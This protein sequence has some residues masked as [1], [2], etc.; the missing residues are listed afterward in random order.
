[1]IEGWVLWLLL[2]GL[3]LGCVATWL[4]MVRLPRGEGDVSDAERP[5]E[6]AWISSVIEYHG[7][8]A[9]RSLVEEVLD[10]HQVYL[11]R[12]PLATPPPAAPPPADPVAH[13][14]QLTSRGSGGQRPS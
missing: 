3:A 14:A 10:L 5:A 4:L 13:P 12:S 6:A 7:G 11:Q 9:P 2:A 1:M 8:V